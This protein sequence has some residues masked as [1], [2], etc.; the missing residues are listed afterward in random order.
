MPVIIGARR[1]SSF[2]D[3][4]GMLSDCH[5][6]IERFLQALVSLATE[7]R[8]TPLD[9][10][11]RTTLETSLRYFRE[12]APKH[13]SDEEDSLF[14]RLRRIDSPEAR[15][16]MARIDALERDHDRAEQSHAEVERLGQLWLGD[17]QL[18]PGDAARL[19]E[20]LAGL[21][22]LYRDHIAFEDR[23]VFPAAQHLISDADRQA[24]GM[25]MALRRGIENRP[26][27]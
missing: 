11:Q 7:S 5:R 15:A 17:G 2:A 3:P 8:G 25:E 24:V 6:R 27:A 20:L 16:L 23:Q 9:P 13:T 4:I 12:A 19:I 18:S 26:K 10:T 14:P 1:E 22:E 21:T